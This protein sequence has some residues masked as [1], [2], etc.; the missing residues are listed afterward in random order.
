M[1]I[2]LLLKICVCALAVGAAEA[3]EPI[4]PNG[5][6]E[7]GGDSPTGWRLHAGGSLASGD[8]RGG[9]RHLHGESAAGAVVAESEVIELRGE[10]DYRLEGWLRAARGIARLG[11]DLLDEQS[12]VRQTI[13]AP[14]VADTDAWRYVAVE[15]RSPLKS[16]RVRFWSQGAA[17]L[18][19]VSI[20][21]VSVSYLGNKSV[22]PDA[23]GRIP[24]WDE[25]KNADLRPGARR[26]EHRSDAEVRHR[27]DASLRL[28]TEGD[29]YAISSVNYPVPHW[30]DRL[31]LS[32]LTRTER[33]ATAELWA[34]WQD[35]M[36]QVLRVD[37]GE[38]ASGE[39]WQPLRVTLTSVPERAATVRLVAACSRGRAWFDDFDLVLMQ[40]ARQLVQVFANQVA[41][42]LGVP[43]SLVVATNFF[44]A[45]QSTAVCRLL[46]AAG[47]VAWQGEAAC[48]GR[49]HG[50][51]D[52]DWGWYFWRVD[53][54]EL[55]EEGTFRAE[56]TVADIRGTSHSIHVG[57]GQLL[58]RTA[59]SA[60]D[61]FFVQRCG[62]N[63]PD[64]HAACHLDD[65]RLKDGSHI[66]VTGGWHSAGDYNKP[67]WQFGDGAAAYALC[68]AHATHPAVF[69][70]HDRD[71]DSRPDALDEARWGAAFLAKMQRADDGL[72]RADVLQGPGRDWMRWLAPERHTD[73]QPGTSDDPV[74]AEGNGNSPL[75]IAAWAALS[76][77]V[78]DRALAE[79]YLARARRLWEASINS[80]GASSNTLLLLSACELHKTTGEQA[81]LDFAQAACR[82]L[83]DGQHER[84]SFSGDTGDHGDVAA[85]A[86]ATFAIQYANDALR[87]RIIAALERYLSFCLSR[88]DNPFG[89][90][91]QGV[92]E[93]NPEY[94]HPFVGLGVNFWLLSR[95]W[96]ALLIYRLN[97][98]QR[99]LA[100]ASDQIDWVLGKNTLHL[101]MFEGHG[102]VNPARYHHRYNMI[103]GRE[104][105]AVPGA[106]PN[107][108][109]RDMG[110]ADRPG[111]DLSR[112]GNRSPSFR[113]SE[114]W[115]VHNVFFLLAASELHRVAGPDQ[116]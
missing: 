63:V 26:G 20:T 113:T 75:T 102:Q 4:L 81:L 94:F 25:E 27:D 66:D 101:C 22:T 37:R 95:A 71:G 74:I 86:L 52:D 65:A 31:E 16:G 34:C 69:A 53:F 112:G 76:R 104:R 55:R 18:D 32:C 41:Y 10:V 51:T 11:I 7:E 85:A 43:K 90:S 97:G 115:L 40:P 110:L 87:A 100:Y 59:Q 103:H 114:P 96:T 109:V 39:S 107:G 78:S 77:S 56:A 88:A 54:S 98:D 13:E 29:W 93:A 70:A 35:D 2:T 24:F 23:R 17:D 49:I 44:P 105:G 42:E 99:A 48:S 89:L 45:E 62:F 6:F 72:L 3:A 91:R 8:S 108:F 36:Q 83:L 50:G 84:G 12:Q 80:E 116:R 5:S 57:R 106:I 79:D 30:T 21:R 9:K 68:H 15:W 67:M 14:L 82:Q 33:T 38:P 92:T 1:S 73:N 28:S 46:D 64:W 111:F 47:R 61:F 60:V 19:D 58:E